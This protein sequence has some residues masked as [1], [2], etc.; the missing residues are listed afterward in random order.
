MGDLHVFELCRYVQQLVQ[1]GLGIHC[2]GLHLAYDGFQLVIDRAHLTPQ[3][4]RNGQAQHRHHLVG[5][6]LQQP[7]HDPSQ[8]PFAYAFG[9]AKTTI[10]TC[11]VGSMRKSVAT[12]AALSFT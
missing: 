7:L 3:P 11:P 10:R 5:L 4:P 1:R 6:D 2:V 9:E 8:P 12:I